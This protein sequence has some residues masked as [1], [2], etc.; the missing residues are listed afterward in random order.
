[1]ND[2]ELI[3]SSDDFDAAIFNLDGVVTR[4]NKIH[5]AAWKHTFDS[6]M[7]ERI[8]HDGEDLRPFN[9][10]LDFRR[11]LD[12][13][14]R[15]VGMK[16]FLAA[17]HITLAPTDGRDPSEPA[18]L[19]SLENLKKRTFDTIVEQKGIDVNGCAIALIHRLRH[20]G[21]KTAVVSA[22]SHCN[23][24]LE[25]EGIETLFD[26]RIDGI[27]AELLELDSKPD[28]YTLL[29]LSSRLGIDPSRTIAIEDSV[30]G[31]SACHRGHFGLVIGVD[32]GEEQVLMHE[33]GADYVLKDL[34]SVQV[35][36]PEAD[37]IPPPEL[38]D[39]EQISNQMAGKIPA[40][41]L[42]YGE[43]LTA[44]TDRP[45]DTSISK[46]MRHILKKIARSMP[47]TI[48]S[49]RDVEEIY[50]QIGLKE[51]FYA[52]NHGLDIRGPDLH[53]ELPEGADA[54]DDL[55][56]AMKDLSRLPAD[57]P[58]LRIERKRFAIVIHY[59]HDNTAS[60]D[61][62]A[63]AAQRVQ[64]HFPRLRISGGKEVL[65][66]LPDIDW[67]KGRA[68]D[69]LLSEMDLDDSKVLPV[70][71]GD[72]V[73][74]ETAFI[75]LHGRGIGILV[76]EQ[77]APSAATYRVKNTKMVMNLLK[78]LNRYLDD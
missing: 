68:M 59:Q 32:D 74:D 8:A 76:A 62:A 39:M 51:L 31:V 6:F 55:D 22:S 14:P 44:V 47:V 24:I 26:A 4:A 11:Y 18:T 57:V 27:E 46:K 60:A 19:R 12:G 37:D 49:G 43:T 70:Y 16:R 9:I 53:L 35:E 15:T 75:T 54:L 23:M 71:I 50:H 33:H 45:E 48:V 58:G 73:T 67:D 42:D 72:D 1:M 38:T 5:A 30:I 61:L 56:Q 10:D 64:S 13:K 34:C 28:P 65:E 63:S 2:Q 7:L 36:E 20:A 17:R 66:L 40:L 78:Y 41:F 21:I 77:P 25:Q 29:E 69:W 3:I 52:G